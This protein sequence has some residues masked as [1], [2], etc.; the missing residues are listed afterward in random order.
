MSNLPKFSEKDMKRLQKLSAVIADM[1]SAPEEVTTARAKLN[2]LFKKYGLTLRDL[3]KLLHAIE[4]DRIDAEAAAAAATRAAG[5]AKG[6]EGTDLGIPGNDL[7]GLMTV[8]SEKYLWVTPEERLAAALWA[9]HWGAA[10]IIE[11]PG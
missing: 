11:T 9:L 8:S 1:A 10:R 7:L 3:P 2:E 4:Q 6:P 5:W